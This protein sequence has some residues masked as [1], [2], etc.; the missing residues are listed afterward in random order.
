MYY[1][2][3]FLTQLSEEVTVHIVTGGDRTQEVIIGDAS[4]GIYFT[5]DPV[6][7]ESSVND[8]FD[9]LLRSEGSIRLLT[10]DF[11][12]DLF[13]TTCMNAV[14]NIFKGNQCIFAGFIEPQAYE[15]GYNEI[16]D[17]LELSCIDVLSAL[18]Y[19]K[20]RDIGTKPG[21]SYRHAKVNADQRSYL[22]YFR[23]LFKNALDVID[24]TG[25]GVKMLYDGSKCYKDTVY[26]SL[27]S[28]VKV[29]ELLF[30]GDEED[31]VW[32]CDKVLEALL[33]Y[34][35]LHIVQDGLTFYVYSW[36]S[37]VRER[38]IEW[39]DL[40]TNQ[41]AEGIK[42]RFTIDLTPSVVA[43]TDAS[44]SIGEVYNRLE[45]T[46]DIKD[47]ETLIESPLEKNC[48]KAR[49]SGR[50]L[51]MKEIMA[52]G[53][54]IKAWKG[55]LDKAILD[56]SDYG[57]GEDIDW[58]I[59][60]K[61]CENWTFKGQPTPNTPQHEV[62]NKQANERFAQL[63]SF[64][65]VEH[66]NSNPSNAVVGNLDMT[67]YLIVPVLGDYNDADT[68]H[69][70]AQELRDCAPMATYT[71]GS[72]GA[73]YSPV[74]DKTTNYIVFSGSLILNPVQDPSYSYRSIMAM[75]DTPVSP[76]DA[77]PTE[78]AIKPSRRG[79]DGCFRTYK[80]Y[81]AETPT[82]AP[83]PNRSIERGLVPFTDT[84]RKLLKLEHTAPE[85]SGDTISKVPVLE[86][87]LIIG[88]KV[89]VE[90]PG[91]EGNVSDFSWKP[92]V[93]F[94][95]CK[96]REGGN[97][98]KAYARY[99][100]Q[101]FSL[102]F[103][104][105]VG[106]FLIGQE[107]DIR[108][109]IDFTMSIEASGTAIPIKASDNLRGAVQF[110]ILGPCNTM[111]GEYTRRHKTWFRPERWPGINRR[112]LAHVDHIF[113]KD[114]EVKVYSD[115][116]HLDNSSD[117]D[118]VYISNTDDTFVNIKDD[119]DFS[120]T[121]ALTSD[122]CN[123]CGVTNKVWLST[124]YS[125][126]EQSSLRA[127]YDKNTGNNDKPEKLYV[128]SYYQEYSK[129][130][131]QMTV[132]VQDKVIPRVAPAVSLFHQYQ[133]PA[134]QGKKFYVIGVSRNVIEGSAELKLKEVWRKW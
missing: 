19:A 130:R 133:H 1:H 78:G 57:A 98:E 82:S 131:I 25:V 89:L 118:L 84:D 4:S 129:P 80:F 73:V 122:E 85:V 110:K 47:I 41:K 121:T 39:V 26:E 60:Y 61:D 104:P 46:C 105:A 65:K 36:E 30:L 97:D 90:E 134:M 86:C 7:I 93:T 67:D 109:N 40:Y 11:V 113:I 103:D 96:V 29:S 34:L 12:P 13:N 77:S 119:L 126:A 64:G 81:N 27:F 45:L 88:D 3:K 124:P 123:A 35:N 71:G 38:A 43:D 91:T 94:E 70:T 24:I 44:I 74:D 79:S 76:W 100:S 23:D 115:N 83:V 51:Y 75:L 14:V 8:T 37:T 17:E 18:Q 92:Y 21:V 58:Y 117:K 54:G 120:I 33:K 69:P 56:R 2:G 52:H 106:D 10:K 50:Q 127:I 9:V 32:E 114:F 42:P 16:Y 66:V 5:D 112:V 63:V 68:G 15:Q 48:L 99:Y 22:D 53:K 20:Y 62:A 111:F 95:E 55:F 116:G 132:K 28:S 102:G 31:D 6:T 49:Y 108:N 72:N 107:Y 125:S 128:D 87:M 101:C 59:L